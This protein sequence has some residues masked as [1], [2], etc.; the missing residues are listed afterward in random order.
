MRK[1]SSILCGHVPKIHFTT[2]MPGAGCGNLVY[3]KHSIMGN[4]NC[5]KLGAF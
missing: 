1:Q 3:L 2:A 5:P 4:M